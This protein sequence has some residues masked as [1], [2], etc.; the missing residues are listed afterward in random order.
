MRKRGKLVGGTLYLKRWA[1]LVK[2]ARRAAGLSC[3]DVARRA[4]FE[5]SYV[6]LFER[7]GYVPHRQYVAA[8]ARALGLDVDRTLLVAGYAPESHQAYLRALAAVS[9]AASGKPVG[10]R[11]TLEQP[12]ADPHW[13][14]VPL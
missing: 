14:G 1:E 6:T 2:S 12:A 10:Q 7:D 5:G 4:G 13:E 11:A 8:L 3:R 9:I